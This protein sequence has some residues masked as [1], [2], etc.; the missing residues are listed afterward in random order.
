M[1]QNDN[2]NIVSQNANKKRTAKEKKISPKTIKTF[3]SQLGEK[4][5]L[6]PTKRLF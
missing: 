6:N 3:K 5:T 2:N 1:N 4:K